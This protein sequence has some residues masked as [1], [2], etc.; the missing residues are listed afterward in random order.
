MVCLAESLDVLAA[1]LPG[2]ANEVTAVLPW[3]SLL[4]AL[5][6]PDSEQ[7]A[8]LHNLCA[9]DARF[10]LVIS[11]DP[12]RDMGEFR[13][14]G[15]G[16]IGHGTLTNGLAGAYELAGFQMLLCEPLAPAALASF[17]TTWAKRLAHGAPRP[18]WR[19]RFRK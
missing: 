8:Y 9:P 15:F 1:E 4:R 10:S 5:V 14:L 18:A 12:A 19:L 11:C 6:L 13:R 17:E 2:F 3:G 7:L 16:E